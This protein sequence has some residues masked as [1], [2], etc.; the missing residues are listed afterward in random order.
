MSVSPI[1]T[2]ITPSPWLL[3]G[4]RPFYLAT[5]AY[6]I[7]LVVLWAMA[8]SGAVSVPVPAGA[9]GA[10]AWHVHEMIYGFALASVAGFLLTAVPEFTGATPVCG[11]PLF[12]L[13][14]LWVAARA[15]FWL[16]GVFTPWPALALNLGFAAALL[17]IFAPAILRDPT[18][19][20]LSFLWALA[21]L[22]VAQAGFFFDVLTGAATLRWLYVAVGIV[23]ILIVIAMSRVSMRLFNNIL[24]DGEGV[25]VTYLARPPRR[26]LATFAIGL[27]TAVEFFAPGNAIAGWLALAAGAALFNLLNDW[28]LGRATFNR[29]ILLLYTVYAQMAVGYALLGLSVLGGWGLAS[30]A[31]HVLL[32]GALGVAIFVIMAIA[33]R[34]HAG[35]WLER[36]RWVPIGA[37]L[38]IFAGLARVLAVAD[39]PG[40]TYVT[41]MA[42]AAL[43]WIAAFG[44]FLGFMWRTLTGPRPDDAGGCAEPVRTAATPED[45]L[46]C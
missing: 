22:A 16:A 20:H 32:I 1:S 31:R 30:A 40:V 42:G 15:A 17:A 29:W 6:A 12:A 3:C 28:H 26:N 7:V 39:L 44:I 33:G 45:A 41:A 23:M 43:A 46:A 36:R 11:R 19:A 13:M 4:F 10:V 9:G 27:Y 5:A 38:L 25:E 24:R 37:V 2:T 18:R 34:I 21:A 35:Y 14:L 8:L